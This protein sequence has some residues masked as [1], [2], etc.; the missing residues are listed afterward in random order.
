MLWLEFRTASNASR[1]RTHTFVL[2]LSGAYLGDSYGTPRTWKRRFGQSLCLNPLGMPLM[3]G[4]GMRG[5]AFLGVAHVFLKLS[6][7]LQYPR[8]RWKLRS[9]GS[10]GSYPFLWSNS[11]WEH[12]MHLVLLKI[13]KRPY[14][15]IYICITTILSAVGF[16]LARSS[17]CVCF[18]QL[19]R[20]LNREEQ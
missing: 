15:Y 14:L 5:G 10:C 13:E 3:L 2:A 8:I 1:F 19:H 7:F 16:V 18:T 11:E 20:W 4:P 17:R 12:V 6:S 9:C